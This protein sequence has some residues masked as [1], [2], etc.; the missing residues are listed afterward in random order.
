MMAL[1]LSIGMSSKRGRGK[2][3]QQLPEVRKTVLLF[4]D[5]CALQCCKKDSEERNYSTLFRKTWQLTF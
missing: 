1:S 3:S 2:V 5:D 4:A